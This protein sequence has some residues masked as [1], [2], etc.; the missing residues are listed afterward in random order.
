[1]SSPIWVFYDLLYYSCCLSLIQD[2][3]IKRMWLKHAV[4]NAPPGLLMAKDLD[5]G[6]YRRMD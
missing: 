5:T 2:S 3:V 6:E 4:P 1:M